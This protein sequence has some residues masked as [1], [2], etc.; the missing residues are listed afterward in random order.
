MSRKR[1]AVPTGGFRRIA[2]LRL[3]SLGDVVLS[4][5]VVHSLK[6]AWPSAEITFWTHEEYGDLVADD[7]A[8]ARVRLLERDA[9]RIEDV[10][11][12]GAE[13]EDFDLIIDLHG[14]LRTRAMTFRQ[15]AP[16]LHAASYRLRR[17]RWV[18]ARWTR[19]RP[20][21]PAT[22]RMAAALA[23]VGVAVR[24]VPAV[25]VSGAARSWAAAHAARWGAGPPPIALCPG[26]KHATKRW[27]EAHWIALHDR[28]RGAGRRL[29]YFSPSWERALFPA[30]VRHVD[31]DTGA[32]WCSEPLAR[33][34][35][36]IAHAGAAVTSDSG[37]MHLAA[38]RGVP[39]VAI[40]G[41]TSPVLG[42]PPAGPGH[43]VLCRN[44]SCQP[45]TLHGRDRCP[46]G[47]HAC[48][49]GITPEQVA[50]AALSRG[51][52]ATATMESPAS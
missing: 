1:L 3:S 41:S 2:V 35:A 49:T 42:F 39:V 19:P 20:V 27:P 50:D 30:L 12:M 46:L 8:L 23:A 14:N 44:L 28:L 32:E 34:A 26:A 29:V 40:F 31:A 36:L 6:A 9:R 18:H 16:V 25:A 45:C 10:V 17:S 7:P 48:M 11:S 37:L 15:K 52:G 38:A 33:I 51:A 22:E 43:V 4:L 47:H 5:P 21:P 24:G 13:L